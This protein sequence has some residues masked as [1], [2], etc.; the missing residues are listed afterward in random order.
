MGLM[1][2]L[3]KQFIDVIEWQEAGDGTLAWRFPMQD[4]EIQNGGSLTVRE[5]QVA[6]FVN[7]G[8]VADVFGEAR[9]PLSD[10]YLGRLLARP[11]FWAYAAVVDGASVGGLT[12]HTLPMTT[13]ERSEVFL[14]D[15]A[16]AAEVQRQGI[17]RKLVETLLGDTR[18]AG[19]AVM[20]VPAD[21]EDIHAIDFYRALGGR[22]SNVT[23]F[24]GLG[25]MALTCAWWGIWQILTGLALG[26]W[27]S[28]R[29]PEPMMDA[30]P[31]P[32]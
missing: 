13:G 22:A 9:E 7:E 29:P 32:A 24:D 8:Q 26:T 14:Y 4:R 25:G 11:G 12:A 3:K 18:Q 6:V 16:V 2:F 5:S 31:V 27:W 17:G 1:D 15:I 21:D 10:R 23:F 30:A 19:I 20:F 28:R